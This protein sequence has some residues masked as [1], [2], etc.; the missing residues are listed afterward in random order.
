MMT[1]TKADYARHVAERFG[2][3]AGIETRCAKDPQHPE[4]QRQLHSERAYLAA[5]IAFHYAHVVI[6]WDRYR[7]GIA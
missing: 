3:D 2:Y 6:C 7:L 5:R 4:W 1:L